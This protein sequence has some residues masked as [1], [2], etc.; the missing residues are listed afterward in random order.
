MRKLKPQPDLCEHLEIYEL[1]VPKLDIYRCRKPEGC[2]H[3]RPYADFH[4]CQLAYETEPEK[5]D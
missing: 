1:R 3:A 4:R 2:E 5:T